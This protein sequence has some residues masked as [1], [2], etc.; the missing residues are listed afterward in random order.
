[1]VCK[2]NQ[3]MHTSTLLKC[4]LA[5]LVI[6]TYKLIPSGGKECTRE[7]QL[8]TWK[9]VWSNIWRRLKVNFELI[10]LACLGATRTGSHRPVYNFFFEKK[11]FMQSVL[12]YICKEA[13]YVV[14]LMLLC[15]I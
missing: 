6:V 12:I 14:V 5:T 13:I 15:D 9:L 3:F 1:M 2:T 11:L 8:A 10:S 4:L 7:S